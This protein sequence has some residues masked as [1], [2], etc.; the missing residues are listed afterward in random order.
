MNNRKKYATLAAS[1]ITM[2]CLGGVYAWSA[3]VPELKDKFGFST[4]G[5]QFIF[6]AMIAVF[7]LFMIAADRIE[8][9]SGPAFLMRLSALF[10]FA[11][12][13][14][15]GFSGGDFRLVLLGVGVLAGIGTGFGYFVSLTVPVRCFPE[16][17]GLVTGIASAGFGLAA[18][19]MTALSALLMK[20][21]YGVLQIFI[22]VGA[23]YGAVVFVSSFFVSA[24]AHEP[25]EK[26]VE[27]KKLFRDL[28]F[29][30]LAA[31]VFC[32]SFSG[33]LVI[34]NL[35]PIGMEHGILKGTLM[36]GISVF[37]FANFSGR[38]FWGWV[39]DKI[40]GRACILT[41]FSF[42]TFFLFL[43]GLV[44]LT[45]SSYLLLAAF[46]GFCFGANF[47]LFA[48]EA[49]QIYGAD[50]LGHVYPYIFLGY[51]AAGISGP[52]TGGFVHDLTGEF[53]AAAYIASAICFAGAALF[54]KFPSDGSGGPPAASA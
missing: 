39:S 48:K 54:L 38:L 28:R 22:F 5:A 47:V 46:I 2:L 35:K 11:G 20:T 26:H 43:L 30:R 8:E 52:I 32:G 4:A 49:A 17:K 34:G 21:G 31:G 7:A 6:G 12:Y 18:I 24:P 42:Q 16:K 37:A 40:S 1:F 9:R 33:L 45:D 29:Y 13:S 27:L 53:T 41:A 25:P 44:S 3:F 51:A 15:A 19:V 14:L 23:A 10:F 50:N 36:L